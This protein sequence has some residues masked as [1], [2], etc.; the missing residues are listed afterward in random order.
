[1][2]GK[3]DDSGIE[4]RLEGLRPQVPS[5][6]ARPKP[7]APDPSFQIGFVSHSESAAPVLSRSTPPSS[8]DASPALRTV[9]QSRPTARKARR[10]PLLHIALR[11]PRGTLDEINAMAL[12]KHISMSQ[13]IRSILANAVR[14]KR[15]GN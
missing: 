6:P 4:W 9:A 7:H 14:R 8:Q 12:E 13:V 5:R 11:I 1:M 15:R 2:A 10:E 3:D